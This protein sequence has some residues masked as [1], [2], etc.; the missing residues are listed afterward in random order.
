MTAALDAGAQGDLVAS[1]PLGRVGSP[2]D[3]ARL[4]DFLAGPGGAYITGQ[5]LVV[6]GGLSL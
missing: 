1:I 6:D 4:V 2:E 5:A 3:V